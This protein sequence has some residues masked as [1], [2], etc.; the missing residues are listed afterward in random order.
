MSAERRAA[1]RDYWAALLQLLIPVPLVLWPMRDQT[2][3]WL[4]SVTLIFIAVQFAAVIVHEAGHALVGT[5]LRMRVYGITIGS[6]RV[7]YTGKIG[8]VNVQV[9]AF[10]LFG[11]VVAAPLGDA[12]LRPRLA[13]LYLA[14]PL[15]NLASA[16]AVSGY[17]G[18]PTQSLFTFTM[19]AFCAVSVLMGVVNLLPFR[20]SSPLGIVES[21]GMR[22]FRSP[23]V[24][25]KEL[26]ELRAADEVMKASRLLEADRFEE[27]LAAIAPVE[28]RDGASAGTAM[29]RSTALI[30]LG[31]NDEAAEVARET[32]RWTE[33]KPAYAVF[34]KNNLAWAL[35]M[36]RRPG[37]EAE[38]DLASLQ[39]VLTVPA[40]AGFQSTRAAVHAWL[41]R[42]ADG[43]AAIDRALSGASL[44]RHRGEMLLIRAQL[45]AQQGEHRAALTDL[46]EGRRLA[47]TAASIRWAE[48]AVIASPVKHVTAA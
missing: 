2:A 25:R 40:L 4:F 9:G 34:A 23:W 45:R 42:T 10:P 20:I 21:D 15:A 32:L 5:V 30:G 8:G 1:S 16:Y 27:A 31:R 48:E 47:P 43:V 26:A 7:L 41:G 6:G 35:A 24:T 13:L 14:G 36:A 38:A 19:V 3:G 22:F 12:L 28:Q 33:L 18:P 11:A 39:I 17:S 37:T 29:V 46:E 44:P